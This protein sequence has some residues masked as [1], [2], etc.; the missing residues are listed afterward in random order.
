M[1]IFLCDTHKLLND[2]FLLYFYYNQITY[3]RH[4]DI[5]Y[6]YTSHMMPLYIKSV[7]FSQYASKLSQSF[8]VGIKYLFNDRAS[9]TYNNNIYNPIL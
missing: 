8:K 1:C 7:G 6:I 2:A 5:I 9:K 3:I 4:L